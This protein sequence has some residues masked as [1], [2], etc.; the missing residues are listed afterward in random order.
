MTRPAVVV[1]GGAGYIGSHTCKELARSGFTP[2]SYDNLSTGNRKAVHWGPLVEGDVRD[3]RSLAD[4][5]AAFKPVA[6]MHFAASAYVGES[7]T[8]PGKY[9]DNNVGG[10][11]SLLQTC[12]Q[13]SVS[14]LIFSSS[15]ATY[16]IPASLPITEE[17]LQRPINPYGRTKLICEH[18]LNDYAQAYGMRYAALRYF[19]ASGADPEA[20]IGEWHEP[21]T[22]LIPR[23]LLAAAGM[24]GE[25]EVFGNDYPTRDGTCIRDYIHVT[26][27]A[28][29]HVL[30]LRFLLQGG[31][32]LQVNLGTERGHS[33]L[34]VLKAIDRVTGKPV[35]VSYKPRRA[36][37][38]P[39]LVADGAKARAR[40]GF[41]PELSDIETI[42]QTA[43]PFFGFEGRP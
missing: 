35:P 32:D 25:L 27:L 6:V 9:Y 10:M 11:I 38:P 7:V 37:D 30:A 23:A 26:D 40:L 41:K 33:I 39:I 36:G 8:D 28:R 3:A 1:T 13:Q 17:T 43:A 4:A 15:C 12:H 16:G 22:H 34:D 19:N 14:T 29:A 5:L 24:A 42:V 31:E 21:E 18:M 2:V 20:E